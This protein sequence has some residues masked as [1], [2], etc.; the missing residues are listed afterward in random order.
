MH[1]IDENNGPPTSKNTAP[2]ISHQIKQPSVDGKVPIKLPGP[3]KPQYSRW[4]YLT[5]LFDGLLALIA[6]G[7]VVFAFL[8][9]VNDGTPAS[10]GSLGQKLLTTASYVSRVAS[11][12]T[13]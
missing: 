5:F 8:V 11:P 9:L 3:F 1:D 6:I 13:N 7:F 2:F 4:R 12:Y 10:P